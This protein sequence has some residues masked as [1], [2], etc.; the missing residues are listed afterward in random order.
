[1]IAS[2]VPAGAAGLVA[3]RV[4]LL[5]C[6]HGVCYGQR[7]PALFQ[8]YFKPSIDSGRMEIK[9]YD[10]H[11]LEFPDWS[12]VDAVIISGSAASVNDSEEWIDRLCQEVK[13]LSDSGKRVLGV[14]FGHQIVAKALGGQVGA[15]PKGMQVGPREFRVSAEGE[16]ALR[17]PNPTYRLRVSHSD[18]VTKMP[19]GALSL[20]LSPECAVE[21][22]LIG[23]NVLSL[24]GHPEFGTEIGIPSQQDLAKLFKEKGFIST[25]KTESWCK[26]AEDS[27][28]ESEGVDRI[29]ESLTS[30]LL[31]GVPGK[32]DRQPIMGFGSLLSEASARST[33]PNL[34]NFR[35]ARLRGYKRVMQHPAAVFFTRGISNLVT[36]EMA[37]LSIEP[38]PEGDFLVAAFDLPAGFG[39]GV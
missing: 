21:G 20:G 7:V 11:K 22:M 35:L 19:P 16:R 29:R 3:L 8:Q 23:S 27:L 34:A 24:Q 30:F 9:P 1:M 38:D 6:D 13:G 2:G 25:E 36:K 32:P 14:C 28:L 26:S 15:H 4:A 37:S 12:Q 17:W 10:V 31:E 39:F 33:F 5:Q 18:M